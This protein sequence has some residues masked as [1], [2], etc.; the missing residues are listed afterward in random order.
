[1]LAESQNALRTKTVHSEVLWALNPTNNISEAIRRYG[2]S[3]TT[4]ALVVVRIG[5][6]DG[7]IGADVVTGTLSRFTALEGLTDWST[8][9]KV[10]QGIVQECLMWLMCYCSTIS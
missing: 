7:S 4:R 3:D 10:R 8:I 9:K 5:E 6:S 2:V 1:M